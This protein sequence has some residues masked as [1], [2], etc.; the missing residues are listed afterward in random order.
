MAT[1]KGMKS[2]EPIEVGKFCIYIGPGG[3]RKMKH[4]VIE[5]TAEGVVTWSQFKTDD[6]ETDGFSWMGDRE[7]FCQNFRPCLPCEL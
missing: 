3:A 1:G 6:L 4:R 7:T 5:S 2:G